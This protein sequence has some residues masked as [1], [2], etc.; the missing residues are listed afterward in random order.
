VEIHY[1]KSPD[2]MLGIII[3]LCTIFSQCTARLHKAVKRVWVSV[4]SRRVCGRHI[5]ERSG[6]SDAR[7]DANAHVL[8]V[9]LPAGP[10]G[11]HSPPEVRRLV[12]QLSTL[13]SAGRTHFNPRWKVKAICGSVYLLSCHCRHGGGYYRE[14]CQD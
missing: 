1:V 3:N 13:P 9:R 4:F 5:N 6:R 7:V 2:D 14:Q 11:T 12:T 8:H 10:T